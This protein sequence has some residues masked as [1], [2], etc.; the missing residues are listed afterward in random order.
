MS[1]YGSCNITDYEEQRVKKGDQL[2]MF[3]D[4]GFTYCLVIGPERK[5]DF[6]LH[7]QTPGLKATNIPVSAK[8]ATVTRCS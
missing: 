5:I 4:A 8:F 2:A 6:D 1:G 7:G 3:H